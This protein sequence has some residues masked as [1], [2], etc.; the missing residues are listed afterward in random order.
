MADDGTPLTKPQ[1]EALQRHNLY[2]F[3]IGAF[4]VLFP[5]RPLQKAPYLEAMCHALQEV[6]N[7]R[8]P[9]LMISIAPRHLKSVC[10]SVLFPAFFLGHFPEKKVMVVSYGGDLAREHGGLF[11]RLVESPFYKRLFAMR[12]DPKHNR[13][14]HMKTTKGGGRQAASLGGSVTGFGADVIIIDDLAKASDMQ[15]EVIREQARTFFDQ[16]LYSRLDN[17]AEARIV[18]I[19]QRLHQD[20]FAVYLLEKGTFHHLCLPS[21]AEIR[22]EI[23]LYRRPW[24][25]EV[26][27]VLSPDREPRFVLEEIRKEIGNYA[28]QAQYQQDPAPGESQYLSMDDLHLVDAVPE[29]RHFVRFAQSW[30]TAVNDGPRSDY[31]VGLTFGWHEEE[32]RWYLMD[33]VRERLKYP[34]LL[35]RIRA[36]RQRWRADK[37]LIENS[38][39]G[40]PALQELRRQESRTYS[41]VKPTDGKVE[42]F[43]GQTD[44]IRSGQIVI[45]TDQ[46]WYDT[47]RREL[48]QFPNATHDDQVDAL[49]QF[50]ALMRRRQGSYLDTDPVTGRRRGERRRE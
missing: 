23:P 29:M 34:E 36:T 18:S 49:T 40:A 38:A 2:L 1:M 46:P 28:F 7:G 5:G 10:G 27:D 44:W 6:A 32:E 20:D 15:S 26:G 21:I 31:S 48:L 4:E 24:I 45:P 17:K 9:R 25:R 33:V 30:D 39:L 35:D 19:Q 11:R 8:S 22:Q 14:E 50:A 3:L 47:F 43:V 13:I 41:G 37:V 42:R 12:I 16:S